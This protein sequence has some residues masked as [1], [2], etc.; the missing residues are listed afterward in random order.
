ML[1]FAK[2]GG[3]CHKSHNYFACSTS[4]SHS[5]FLSLSLYNIYPVTYVCLLSYYFIICILP[6]VKYLAL[7]LQEMISISIYACFQILLI[8]SLFIMLLYACIIE[9]KLIN[10]VYTKVA[11]FTASEK[12]IN[13]NLIA[14]GNHE[15]SG[16][17]FQLVWPLYKETMFLTHTTYTCR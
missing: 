5:L 11:A 13:T 2:R 10:I 15:Y 9:L 7:L 14:K 12:S 1:I 17:P 16:Q 8:F 4:V 6:E 3:S